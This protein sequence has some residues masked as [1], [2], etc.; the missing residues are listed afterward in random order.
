MTDPAHHA[1][2]HRPR[3]WP[4]PKLLEIVIRLDDQYV[5]STQVMAHTH[6]HVAQIGGK[7]YLY[8]LC[9]KREAYRVGGI[10]WNRKRFDLDVTNLEAYE[11]FQ[12]AQAALLVRRRAD[13]EIAR[14]AAEYALRERQGLWQNRVL[15]ASQSDVL[16]PIRL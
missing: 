10:V 9:S 6:R 2:L 5:A 7:S 15:L 12:R 3:I 1:L 11:A 4:R 8:S 16:E 14:E 13:N